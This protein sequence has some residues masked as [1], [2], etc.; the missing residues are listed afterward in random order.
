MG[1]HRLGLSV[2]MACVLAGGTFF[3][4][5]ATGAEEDA[6]SASQ[7]VLVDSPLPAAAVALT[8][9]D[10]ALAE[11]AVDIAN[12]Q[13]YDLTNS[14]RTIWIAPGKDGSI[15]LFDDGPGATC[16]PDGGGDHG[17][18]T[19]FMPAPS[20]EFV[21]A[22]LD[23]QARG[24][25]GQ[26]A[27]DAVQDGTADLPPVAGPASY[28]GYVPSDLGVV[29]VSLL[30]VDGAVLARTTPLDGVYDFRVADISATSPAE[31]R[32]ERGPGKAPITIGPFVSS[33]K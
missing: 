25:D 7:P 15:C 30:D 11:F 32:L 31:I 21:Q 1:I 3:A 19:A 14:D 26:G 22:G 17:I 5:G 4:A 24:L 6:V 9:G 33:I 28:V 12:A 8:T 13:G 10:G 20:P 16:A 18:M 27:V 29:A 23:A 2:A